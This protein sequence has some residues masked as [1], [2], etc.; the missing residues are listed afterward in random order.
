MRGLVTSRPLF[1]AGL[2]ILESGAT[3]VSEKRVAHS[4]YSRARGWRRGGLLIAVAP[5][6]APGA[7]D[8]LDGL[9]QGG[10]LPAERGE[11][12]RPGDR[13]RSRRL[14]A[15]FGE[16]HPAPVQALLAAP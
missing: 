11:L 14:A 2:C 10:G 16:V 4:P 13:D 3:R 1:V 6:Q 12:A 5:R 9:A 7:V 8:V 15:L